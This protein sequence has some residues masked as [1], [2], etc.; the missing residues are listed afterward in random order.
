MFS[1]F[2]LG[3]LVTAR[4]DDCLRSALLCVTQAE[5][6]IDDT[7]NCT[8]YIVFSAPVSEVSLL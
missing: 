3:C 4:G 2:L 6:G 7:L 8:H 5:G 1:P